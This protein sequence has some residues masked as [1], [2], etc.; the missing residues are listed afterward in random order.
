MAGAEGI[1]EAAVKVKD[2]V[3]DKLSVGAESL[4]CTSKSMGELRF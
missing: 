1:K 3:G 4:S 2:R